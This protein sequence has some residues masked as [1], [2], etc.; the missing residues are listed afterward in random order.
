MCE[1]AT[2]K[3]V[4]LHFHHCQ[5]DSGHTGVEIITMIHHE[6]SESK[7]KC[8]S[9]PVRIFRNG[10]TVF[11]VRWHFSSTG[12]LL[13]KTYSTNAATAS[14]SRSMKDIWKSITVSV[15][16][17][18]IQERKYYRT[19]LKMTSKN[20][21][22]WQIMGYSQQ[23]VVRTSNIQ[24][25]IRVFC[26][27]YINYSIIYSRV[28]LFFASKPG[29]VF[30][31][32][33]SKFTF[34]GVAWF[35]LMILSF[36]H[37]LSHDTLILC[38]FYWRLFH[39]SLVDPFCAIVSII[40]SNYILVCVCVCFCVRACILLILIMCE[41]VVRINAFFFPKN[42]LDVTETYANIQKKFICHTSSAASVKHR[43]ILSLGGWKIEMLLSFFRGD[44]NN[45]TSNVANWISTPI[46]W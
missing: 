46:I 22:T 18:I 20:F 4:N 31:S 21:Y 43:N 6:N 27:T 10:L 30:Q 19:N 44:S 33:Y 2:P 13:R 45:V 16:I 12:L 17:C 37:V 14:M 36:M 8:I 11:S 34:T 29:C 26:C 38:M 5:T 23:T 39:C 40:S 15:K 35:Y 9:K 1:Y 32:T 25:Y 28:L 42:Q 24:S 41:Y 7:Q 3:L